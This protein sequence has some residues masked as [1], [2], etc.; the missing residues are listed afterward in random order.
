MGLEQIFSGSDVFEAQETRDHTIILVGGGGGGGGANSVNHKVG[1]GGGGGGANCKFIVSLIKNQTYAYSVGDAG[2]AGTTTTNGGSGGNTTF[3]VGEITYSAG[4]GTG[5]QAFANGYQ[6]GAGGSASNGDINHSG[7]TG[8]NGSDGSGSGGGGG[9]AG[10]TDNGNNGAT[11][12]GGAAKEDYGGV[13]AD[14]WD[15]NNNQIGQTPSTGY[16]GGGSGGSRTG[17]GGAGFAGYIRIEWEDVI[18]PSA[19][20]IQN[21]TNITYNSARLNAEVTYDGGSTCDDIFRYG[22]IVD[23]SLSFDNIDDYVDVGTL[24]NFGSSINLGTLEFLLKPTDG[25]LDDDII[26]GT[27]NDSGTCIYIYSS[28]IIGDD[29]RY[30]LSLG[31]FDDSE[32]G[33]IGITIFREPYILFD[34]QFHRISVS[35]DCSSSTIKIYLDGKE[36]E[37]DYWS[38][39]KVSDFSNFQYGMMFGAGNNA[40]TPDYYYGGQLCD[41]R[42]WD[43]V[44]TL[45]QV[46]DNSFS[47]IDDSDKTGLVGYWKCIEGAG[48]SVEDDSDNTYSGTIEGATWVDDRVLTEWENGLMTDSPFSADISSLNPRTEYEFQAKLRNEAGE[49]AWSDYEFFTTGFISPFP[50]FRRP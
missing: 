5:G 15:I 38:Q 39:D 13:G 19:P 8:G 10:T 21:A 50:C 41:I 43:V 42:I 16:G 35:Y 9:G 49:S 2:D 3:V 25:S 6:G 44:R 22:T 45:Q 46:Y 27:F 12:N 26:I 33:L 17:A 18:A 4:G 34:G 23:C 20:T 31:V 32:L 28:V 47:R 24:G 7:G 11:P 40:G 37:V 36:L 1:A 48:T 30:E 29:S 14:G